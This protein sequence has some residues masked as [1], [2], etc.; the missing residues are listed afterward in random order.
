MG[1][2]L[3]GFAMAII[4]AYILSK[5]IGLKGKSFFLI[6]LPNYKLPLPKNIGINVVEKTKAFVFGAGKVILA[7]S[8]V[9]WFLASFGPGE[10]FSNAEAYVTT[11]MQASGQNHSAAEIS[12]K[13]DAYKLENSYIGLLGKAIEPAIAPLGFDWKIG[14]AVLSSF[15]AREVFVGTLATI[16]SVGDS[17]N[18]ETIKTKMGEE[19]RPNGQKVFNA[20]TGISLLV[21]YAFAMQCASTLAI[22]RKETNSWKWPLMQL[23]FMSA[24]A[25]LTAL[26]AYQMMAK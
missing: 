16:Y 20:A 23:F 6:E 19:R 5:T 24:F 17:G 21:F 18:E 9:L 15:A 4:S 10:A 26:V 22:T 3:A 11:Q 12:Q 25:Y 2:Y 8:V 1:L 14:I 7:I 13:V